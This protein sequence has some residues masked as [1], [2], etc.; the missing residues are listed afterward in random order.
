MSED[1]IIDSTGERTVI[2][3][4]QYSEESFFRGFKITGTFTDNF[5][6]YGEWDTFVSSFITDGK[7]NKLEFS[8]RFIYQNH[9]KIYYQGFRKE[10]NEEGTGVGRAVIVAADEEFK[11]LLDNKCNYSVKFFNTS[12]FLKQK[13]KLKPDVISVMKDIKEKIN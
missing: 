4:H 9:K 10:G 5:G 3:E 1:Y 2:T 11:K 13:C 12:V 6:N 8:T 7:I